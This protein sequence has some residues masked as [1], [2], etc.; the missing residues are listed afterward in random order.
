VRTHHS[1]SSD[2]NNQRDFGGKK[3]LA[4]VKPSRV[5]SCDLYS[6]LL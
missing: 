1:L 2:C 6:H 5:I 3:T 4:E